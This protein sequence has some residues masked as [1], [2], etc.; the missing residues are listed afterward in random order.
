M[1]RGLL[2]AISN[3]HVLYCGGQAPSGSCPEIFNLSMW[4]CA[5]DVVYKGFWWVS[6][7]PFIDGDQEGTMGEDMWK[8]GM[9]LNRTSLVR[10]KNSAQLCK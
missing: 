5:N 2:G 1:K 9:G 6:C 7:G 10:I 8:T 4:Y 3:F